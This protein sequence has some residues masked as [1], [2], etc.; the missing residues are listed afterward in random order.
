MRNLLKSIAIVLCVTQYAQAAPRELSNLTIIADPSLILPLSEL[1]RDY[2]VQKR[3]AITL[4]SSEEKDPETLI[5]EGMEAHVLISAD[6]ELTTQLQ[7]RGQVDVFAQ[8]PLVRTE[9]VMARRKEDSGSLRGQW[10]LANLFLN[11]GSAIPI[12]L[13]NPAHYIEGSRSI[14]ALNA[15]EAS[16]ESRVMLDKKSELISRLKNEESAGILLGPDVLL[17]P[18][19]TVVSVIPETQYEPI[20]FMAL[21]LASESMPKARQLVKF[22]QSD[23]AASTFAH[24]GFK[25]AASE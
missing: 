7:L 10:T 13:L 20:V 18:E 25:P 8:S 11:Q 2:S 16:L 22:L 17:D 15:S 14:A 21:T 19:L 5:G 3:V 23:A 9:L 1:V 4:V 24:Y 12:L 6:T